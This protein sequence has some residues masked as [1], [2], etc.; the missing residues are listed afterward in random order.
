MK[1][2][3]YFSG[4]LLICGAAISFQ[5]GSAT[6]ASAEVQITVT[7]PR[8]TCNL[9]VQSKYDLGA[10]P[11]GEFAHPAF[12]V[13]IDCTGSIRTVLTARNTTGTLQT[14]NYRVAIPINGSANSWGPFMWLKNKGGRNI[15]LTGAESDKFCDLSVKNRVCD[16]TPVTNVREGAAYGKGSVSIHFSI[17]YPA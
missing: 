15:K 7:S 11:P 17:I 2:K 14:D 5:A 9:T 13:R 3:N 10:L 4:G 16:V 6:S 8:P 12:P 1:A